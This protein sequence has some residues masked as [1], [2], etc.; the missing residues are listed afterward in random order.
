MIA[1][2]LELW[3]VPAVFGH[4]SSGMLVVARV[5]RSNG[6]T[7]EA[8]VAGVV[9]IGCPWRCHISCSHGRLHNRCS[10]CSCSPCC[11]YH[12]PSCCPGSDC[13]SC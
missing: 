8:A 13:C 11:H 10:C 5:G 12:H 7:G 6:G 2:L 3:L 4:A 9:V 1:V